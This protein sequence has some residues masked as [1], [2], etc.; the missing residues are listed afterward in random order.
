MASFDIVCEID[1]QE[2][3]NALEQAKKEIKNRYDFRDSN[4]EI[5]FNKKISALTITA[6]NEYKMQATIDIL[7][8]K[9]IK[10]SV[11][12]KSL[13]YGKTEHVGRLQKK[14]ITIQQG[15]SNEQCKIIHQFIKS[16]KIKVQS[17]TQSDSVR[18]IGK[19][20]DDLQNLINSIKKQ[21]FDFDIQFTNFR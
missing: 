21:N 16:S 7:L 10:R 12:V 4:C 5:D 8:T 20:K 13:F 2:V 15:L 19:K 3:N 6:D 9:L 1:M 17:Q 14:E 18:V 11:P